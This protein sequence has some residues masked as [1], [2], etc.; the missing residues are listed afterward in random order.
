MLLRKSQTEGRTRKEER[1]E[2]KS[3]ISKD[4]ARHQPTPPVM[5]GIT[6]ERPML[7]LIIQVEIVICNI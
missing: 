4:F 3:D 1:Q 6:T 7:H 2:Q 5:P